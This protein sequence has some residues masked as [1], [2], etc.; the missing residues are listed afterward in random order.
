MRKRSKKDVVNSVYAILKE[1]EPLMSHQ[2]VNR[3]LNRDLIGSH[4]GMSS[5]RLAKLM[6][7]DGRFVEVSR[8]VKGKIIWG[9]KGVDYGETI[10]K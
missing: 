5:S 3:L 4:M 2:L 1:G 7:A 8:S 10:E 9:I 6:S